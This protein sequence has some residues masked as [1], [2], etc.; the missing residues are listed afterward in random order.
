LFDPA[1]VIWYY[2]R[3][4]SRLNPHRTSA[5]DVALEHEGLRLAITFVPHGPVFSSDMV[6]SFSR[7][8][9][10]I[11]RSLHNSHNDEAAKPAFIFFPVLISEQK[12]EGVPA[13]THPFM[14]SDSPN[15]DSSTESNPRRPEH[16][17]TAAA[18][19]PSSLP[20][21]LSSRFMAG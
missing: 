11:V 8:G 21:R 16:K 9:C 6:A 17:T 15:V 1:K 18:F 10:V 19:R 2:L 13:G 12:Q 4:G 3:Q 20:L 7:A 14:F 5:E